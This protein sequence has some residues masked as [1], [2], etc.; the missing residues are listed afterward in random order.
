VLGLIDLIILSC[1]N[2]NIN[3]Q[4][5]R[6]LFSFLLVAGFCLTKL[7]FSL[8]IFVY[9]SLLIFFLLYLFLLHRK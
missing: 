7:I 5:V 3:L 6:N 4:Y 9:I 2:I 8:Q 1:W